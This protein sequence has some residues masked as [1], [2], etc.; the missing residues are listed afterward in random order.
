M[1]GQGHNMNHLFALNHGQAEIQSQIVLGLT[2]SDL[3]ASKKEMTQTLKRTGWKEDVDWKG[4]G[5]SARSSFVLHWTAAGGIVP[6][7]RVLLP[8]L[9]VLD[10]ASC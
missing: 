2:S 7:K 6:D 1:V 10:T 9:S 8:A 3:Q 5:S 4:R